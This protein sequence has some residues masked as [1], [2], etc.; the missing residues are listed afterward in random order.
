[1]IALFKIA[2]KELSKK[3]TY[4]LL[5]FFICIIAMNTT[6]NS[7]TNT[8]AEKYQ[9]KILNRNISYDMN[10]I[11]HIKYIEFDESQDFINKIPR[12]IEYI[13]SLDGVEA[14]GKFDS[15]SENFKELTK[16]EEFKKINEKGYMN[17]QY[18]KYPETARVLHIDEEILKL[19]KIELDRYNETD[20][21]PI[22]VSELYKDIL[23]IGTLLT[24][25]RTN[26]VYEVM[27]FFPLNKKWAN[28]DD[29]IRFPMI[30]LNEYFIAPFS[31][32]DEKDILTQLCCLQNTY[33]IISDDVNLENLKVSI[34]KYSS[35]QNFKAT[36]NT[37]DEEYGLYSNEIQSF[38]NRRTILAVFICVMASISVISAFTTNV[39]LKQK[40]YGIYIANGFRKK[41][42]IME[43]GF[44]IAMIIIPSFIIAWLANLI[45]L[46]FSDDIGIMMFRYVFITAHIEFTFWI[47]LMISISMIFFAMLLPSIKILKYEPYMLIGDDKYGI[48]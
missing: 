41:D 30:S 48:Y 14:V 38:A 18:K 5:L 13:S 42:I 7:V 33:V 21:I 6:V 15:T 3:K 43:I 23:P 17:E 35:L 16:L 8:T 2:F 39:I 24:I 44:E 1:M 40:Q 28:E 22:Y 11:L 34:E 36:F 47:C 20:N 46:I 19:F 25:E 4:T 27:G 37:L 29:I 31:K 12:F 26:E 9:Q 10:N 45:K 32:N